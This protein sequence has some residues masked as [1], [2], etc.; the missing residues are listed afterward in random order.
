MD[1]WD[2]MGWNC[3]W[4]E[5]PLDGA[6]SQIK[7]V[8][9]G[10]RSRPDT[11]ESASRVPVPVQ[12]QQSPHC[13]ALIVDHPWKELPRV[14]V[15]YR[16][17]LYLGTYRAMLVSTGNSCVH[18][19]CVGWG[20]STHLSQPGLSAWNFGRRTGGE[21]RKSLGSAHCILQKCASKLVVIRGQ[22]SL[23]PFNLRPLIGASST[24]VPHPA[25][26]QQVGSRD[27]N[28]PHSRPW[29][30]VHHVCSANQGSLGG[31][32]DPVQ[33]GELST[34]RSMQPCLQLSGASAGGRR[35]WR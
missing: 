26:F 8:T 22:V 21:D 20:L 31:C 2:G 6:L 27:I 23:G 16:W 3:K 32:R 12:R 15:K 5:K 29:T 33:L 17:L 11:P 4:T 13:R 35:W 28:F 19:V 7:S 9:D 10:E 18:C 1:G 24:D 30:L 25:G 34:R 14:C